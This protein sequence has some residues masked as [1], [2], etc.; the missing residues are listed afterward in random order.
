MMKRAFLTTA[1][2]A[3][4]TAAGLGSAHAQQ[5]FKLTIAS[6]HPTT[7][8][9]VGLMSSLFV[10][11]VNKRVAALN[12][13]YKIEWREAY[14]GQLYK[15]N[16]TLT[17]VEQGITDI[18]W[19][20]HNL[21]AAKMPLSQFG[22]VTPFTTDDV[23][24][25]LD[26]ANE[27]ND[28]V[29]ALQKEWDRNN[30]VFLGA[31]GVDTYHLFTKNP[32]ATYADLKGRKISAPGS[33]GL[34]LK[35]SGAVPVDGSLTS[36]YTDIQ[37]GVSEGTIS[38]ATGIL[39]NKIYEVAP[40]ITTVNIGALY[41][42]GMAMNKDSY[43]GL[44]PEVQQI[45]KDVGKEYSKALG[46]TLMQRYEAAIK[47]MET[48]GAKQ[49]PSVRVTNMSSGERDK[50]VKTMPNLAAEWARTNA[51]KG[52]AKEIVQT[53]MDALRKRGV[54]PARDWDKEL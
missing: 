37:T 51:S 12:K 9:W 27:M 49:T 4:L 28:K 15:M 38:I 17:S 25:I 46:A 33:I 14:G 11:E 50:W 29:P 42:G 3:A 22:T 23:R 16:A 2:V 7:L 8:P 43:A 5:T 53:Y 39:P 36:Y 52:P 6:S 30:M 48:N 13:G 34:W 26:V 32:I 47:T 44:P 45:V 54:K 18:G 31:T 35:G 1:L 20:F 24:I 41:I 19:V 10:P 21:E 40:Y